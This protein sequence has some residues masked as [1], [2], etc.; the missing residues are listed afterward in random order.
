MSRKEKYTP[1]IKHNVRNVSQHVI[2]SQL[3][4]VMI[5][6][7]RGSITCLLNI[8]RR[9]SHETRPPDRKKE[10]NALLFVEI[11]FSDINILRTPRNRS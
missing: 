2:C 7:G 6:T 5:K 10:A 1:H 8:V 11:S 3:I 4:M 9:S